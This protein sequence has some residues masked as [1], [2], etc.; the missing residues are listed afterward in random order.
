MP[1]LLKA[2]P[3][4]RVVNGIDV[5]FSVDQF[6]RVVES[7]WEGVRNFQ[8]R[9]LL[10]DQLKLG[11]NV[12]FYHSST[13]IPGVVALATVTREGYPDATAWTRG[14][15]YF[16]AKSDPEQPRWFMVDVRFDKRLKHYVALPLLQH[17]AGGLSE[18]ERADVAYLTDAHIAAIAEMPLLRRSRLSVQPV[19]PEA[20]DA[21]CLLGTKGGFDRWPG[22]WNDREPPQPE[23]APTPHM[24]GVQRKRTRRN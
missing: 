9:N 4:P 14:H 21:V 23:S 12:L 13:K 7:Q 5:S 16:D 22:K 8:A 18:S 19:S 10:R 3:H 1:W 24:Q 11:D 20:Y 17:I 6:E 2:E 15:P